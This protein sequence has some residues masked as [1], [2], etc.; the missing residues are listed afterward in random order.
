MFEILKKT[1]LN[2]NTEEYVINAPATVIRAMGQGKK[3]A[4]AIQ[5]A[6]KN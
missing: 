2:A 4:S 5:K 3:A 1:R 6:F